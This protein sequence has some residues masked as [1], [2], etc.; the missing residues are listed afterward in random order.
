MHTNIFKIHTNFKLLNV[1]IFFKTN[2]AAFTETQVR[3][4]YLFM[5]CYDAV[6][7][8]GNVV[9]HIFVIL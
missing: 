1:T 8:Y 5:R 9:T 7:Y 2:R 6:P 3:N 4:I